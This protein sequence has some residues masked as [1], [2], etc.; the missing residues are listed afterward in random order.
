MVFRYSADH[1]AGWAT[2]IAEVDVAV[3]TL[4]INFFAEKPLPL[5]FTLPLSL[6]LSLCLTSSTI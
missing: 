6:P 2:L 3:N 4:G 1:S 5:L